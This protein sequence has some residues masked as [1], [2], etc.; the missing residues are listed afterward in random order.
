M[1]IGVNVVFRDRDLHES[2]RNAKPP[3]RSRWS[4]SRGRLL[5]RRVLPRG[6]D[7]CAQD[8]ADDGAE[9]WEQNGSDRAPNDAPAC[10]ESGAGG[11]GDSNL[12]SAK[13]I[14][15]HP[16]MYEP[17]PATLEGLMSRF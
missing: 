2:E 15:L 10:H 16:G 12:H 13:Q 14:L 5:L 1:L 7:E 3:R 17:S 11:G 8:R 4:G 9:T 6:T